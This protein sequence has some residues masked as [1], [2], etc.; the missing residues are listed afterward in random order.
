LAGDDL[1]HAV[2]RT[3]NKPLM[4]LGAE[5]RLFFLAIVMGGATLNFFGSLLASIL[6]FLALYGVARWA[7]VT[8]EQV[9]RILL[10]ASRYR[11]RY[12]PA[13]FE[14]YSVVRI[15]RDHTETHS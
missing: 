12:D 13:K 11:S 15:R 6:M 4:I 10:N 5:R 8:D 3:L 1:F 7:T 9:F 14:R 2:Y